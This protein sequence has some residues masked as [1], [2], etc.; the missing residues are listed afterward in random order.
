[1][2]CI[3]LS[4]H[5]LE[6]RIALL[7]AEL[8]SLS[9]INEPS[10]LKNND[11]TYWNRIAPNLFPIVGRLKDD[12]FYYDSK[13]HTMSQHGFARNCQFLIQTKEVDS[14][15]LRLEN[16]PETHQQYPFEFEFQIG[17]YLTNTGIKVEY[18]TRN[19]GKNTM[20]FS[21]GGHP[22]FQLNDSI[23][24]YFLQFEEPFTAPISLLNGPYYSG[25]TKEITVNKK[26]ELNYAL[27]ENDAL[28]FK[29]PPFQSVKLMHSEKGHLVTLT[30]DQWDA[31]GFWTKKDAP[32][33]CLEP[34]WGWADNGMSTGD[35][36]EKQG[37]YWIEPNT[38]KT[39][40]FNL[41]LYDET[42]PQ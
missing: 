34:W 6:A 17:F 37:L 33:I 25:E 1:M 36:N 28:V 20:P 24:H 14:V 5:F 15:V 35:L 9:K 41:C 16:S 18:T 10:I 3:T 30:S 4:N 29:N 11:S 32:F 38:S 21:V 12:S 27:F 2:N 13:R 42:P 31:I 19:N 7:G 8:V 23:D 22:G 40:S 39:M 26:L